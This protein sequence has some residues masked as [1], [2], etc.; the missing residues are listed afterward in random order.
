MVTCTLFLFV[1]YLVFH[2]PN[3]FFI[4]EGSKNWFVCDLSCLGKAEERD[5]LSNRSLP[6]EWHTHTLA[7]LTTP[8][9]VMIRCT[10]RD[11]SRHFTQ[12]EM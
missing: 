9:S 8:S 12:T 1:L 5:V 6:P 3:L 11:V 10:V 7:L 4:F 2:F